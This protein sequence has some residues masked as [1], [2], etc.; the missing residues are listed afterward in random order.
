MKTHS[1]TQMAA[2]ATAGN[3]DITAIARMAGLPYSV[4]L[5]PPL[6]AHYAASDGFGAHVRLD[7]Y[8]LVWA[9]RAAVSGTMPA[10]SVQV[11]RHVVRYF[12]DFYSFRGADPEPV[13][14]AVVAD[15]CTDTEPGRLHLRLP[16]E[17]PSTVLVVED[18]RD[19]AELMEIL[20][21][22]A[23]FRVVLAYTAASGLVAAQHHLPDIVVLDFELPDAT[24]EVVFRGLRAQPAT[25]DIP[26]VFCS[27]RVDIE[28]Q[29]I[30]LGA[31]AF[32]RKP[33]DLNRLAECLREVLKSNEVK[34][35]SDFKNAQQ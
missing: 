1:S 15:V 25:K 13:H 32:L 2:V 28:S 12:F 4:P 34:T 29:V 31:A 24:G 7:L 30:E 10:N 16:E 22:S 3:H 26:A 14:C 33:D 19:L 20:L 8:D 35:T 18:N 23:G 5:S 27:G 6:A 21:Q 11:D 17:E 9:A